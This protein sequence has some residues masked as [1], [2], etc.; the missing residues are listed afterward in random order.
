MKEQHSKK[1]KCQWCEKQTSYFNSI[2]IP[3][4]KQTCVCLNCYNKEI[5][6]SA[7]IDFENIQLHPV[8]L[9][10]TDNVDHEFHFFLRLMGEKQ[11]LRAFE[12]EGDYST[13]YE[14]SML[15]ETEDGIFPL[16]SNLYE[17]MIKTLN[18]K[19]IFKNPDT[20]DWQI[21]YEDIVRG[22][23]S[24]D[25]E[26]NGYSRTPMMVIDGKEVSWEDFGQMLMT[27]EGFNFKLQIF[28]PS[29]EMD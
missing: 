23:I 9:K 28:D 17:R 7:G 6:K 10:D 4:D 26:T 5:S 24:C 20:D 14:F 8:I 19:H 25:G 29:D 13:G 1:G 2:L 11:S 27:Y 12:V 3:G 15:G 21:A 16:F 22:Q 18:K